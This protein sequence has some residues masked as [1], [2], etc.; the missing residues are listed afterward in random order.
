MNGT[1]KF[2]ILAGLTTPLLMIAVPSVADQNAASN[3][4]PL[5]IKFAGCYQLN[6]GRWW[7]W[8]FGEDNQFVTPPQR[9]ELLSEQGTEGWE[10]RHLLLRAMPNA[11]G[12][13]GPSFWEV[14]DENR[15]DLVWTDGFTGLTVDLRK[16]GNE[17]R[18]KGHPHFDSFVLIRRVAYVK[19]RNIACDTH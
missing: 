6:L 9:I 17:F 11:S 15:I 5:D 8:G 16:E 18:G 3:R 1:I 19:M 14:Q 10:R 4:S 7:P 12:R 13:K 2:A